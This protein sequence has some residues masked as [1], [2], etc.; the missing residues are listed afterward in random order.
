M[1]PRHPRTGSSERARRLIAALVLLCL[2]PLGLLTWFSLSLSAKAVRSQVDA[3]VQNTASASAVYVREQMDG[4]AE[5]VGSYAKRPSVVGAMRQPATRRNRAT[6][7]FHL[8]ELQRS[9]RGID[10]TFATE[11][12]GRLLD[13]VP[14]TPSIVGRDF[15]FQDWYKGVTATGQPYVS[16]AYETA[17]TGHARV[18]GAAVPVRDPAGGG[19]GRVLGILVAAYGLDT[20]Q[21]FVDDYAAAQGIRLTV[22]DQRGV[23][24]AAPGTSPVGL[25]SRRG[26]PLVDAALQG[27]SGVSERSTF[28]GR[29]VSAYEPVPS[30]GWAVTA[31]VAT[32][33]AFAPIADLRRTVLAFGAVL[34]LALVVGLALLARA[35]RDRTRAE[36]RVVDGE[37]RTRDILEATAEAFI[38]I[39]AAGVV[40]LWNSKATET[41]GW[42]R[43]EA[44]GRPLT[45]LIIPEASR[46]A[47]DRG[48][49]RF[50]ETGEGPLL[51]RRVEVTAVDKDGHQFPVELVIWPAG[52]GPETAF[53][54]FAHDISE[55]RRNEEA[56]RASNERLGLALDAASMGYW[57]RD[58]VSGRVVWSAALAELLGVEHATL[59]HDLALVSH[60]HPQDREAVTRWVSGPAGRGLAD[61]LQFRLD[62]PEAATRWMSGRARVYLDDGGRPVR[63]VGV[64]ADVTERRRA[65][66]A[67]EQAKRDADRANRAKSDFLSKMSHELRTPLNAILGFGQLLQLD[68]L[69]PEQSESVDHML[70]GGR[71]LLELI[72][73]VLDISRIESGN[74]SLSPE[75][76]D[77][78]EVVRD[79]VDLIRPLA[80]ERQI[81]IVA[82]APDDPTVAVQADRQRLKQVL[83]NL[84]SNAVKYNRH[85]GTIRVAYQTTPE[86][87]VRIAV[88]DTGPGLSADKLARL[89]SPFDRLGAEETEV[90][91][92][93]MGLA[94]SKGLVEAM[95]GD[96]TA[97]SVEGRGTTFTVELAELAEVPSRS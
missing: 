95:G 53:N 57:D 49:R 87:R 76:V 17:A 4:L 52:S 38:S 36:Q 88:Q 75:P 96:L 46:Q 68:D 40:T 93:G 97:D 14:D 86:G 59:D 29:V 67:I 89:F 78:A 51:N 61:E 66:Q 31:D 19:Q 41:F 23:V 2:A 58:L 7:A 92:T 10:V 30:L 24:L 45:E 71:H 90:E 21:R 62:G 50:L 25:R 15:S 63:K 83:L 3:R 70:R 43:D 37:E 27:R 20:I 80:A 39:D 60:V 94:L 47:H 91:G 33:T 18:V 34:G 64:V 82:P 79:T 16:E 56:V 11:P 69:S 74:L 5:L 48:R 8:Q 85:A 12:S 73:E 84:A 44:V 28:A 77:L 35:L 42:T 6:I 32:G 1:R 13:V 72:N 26:D 81:T 22:T 65:E 9:R 54:A 55:R